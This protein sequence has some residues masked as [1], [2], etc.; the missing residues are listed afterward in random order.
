MKNLLVIL[1]FLTSFQVTAQTY[2][3]PSEFIHVKDDTITIDKR[4]FIDAKSRNGEVKT[5]EGLSQ[6]E[7]KKQSGQVIIEINRTQLIDV[8]L[9]DGQIIDFENLQDQ[10]SRPNAVFGPGSGGGGP[11]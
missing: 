6:E 8:Q 10:L 5:Y 11:G 9:P 4:N 3:Y 1:L 2:E 7:A